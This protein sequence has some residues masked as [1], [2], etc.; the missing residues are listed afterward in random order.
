M[1]R[2]CSFVDVVTSATCPRL[3]PGQ[4]RKTQRVSGEERPAAARSG[5]L[6][7]HHTSGG[8][9]GR[10]ATTPRRI[11]VQYRCNPRRDGGTQS[12]NFMWWHRRHASAGE[13]DRTGQ[14]D[15]PPHGT[16]GTATPVQRIRPCPQHPYNALCGG[17]VL[18]D[19]ELRRNDAAFLDALG[20]RSIP[21]PTTAGDFCRRFG[22]E[23][24]QRLMD[25]INDV[26]V[27][28]WQ[29]QSPAFFKGT[30][31]ID[32]DGRAH[33]CR[34]KAPSCSTP[35]HAIRRAPSH[36][37]TRSCEPRN[38]QAED[39]TDTALADLPAMTDLG[40]PRI[41]A[42]NASARSWPT[43][44]RRGSASRR[45]WRWGMSD[46]IFLLPLRGS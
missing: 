8:G 12:R 29:R 31:R 14:G 5:S 27:G 11:C 18:D 39:C 23:D 13:Q 42:M 26:R 38:F 36:T 35:I 34:E 20:A 6:E 40:W 3:L 16:H 28:V 21:D 43:D 44:G 33:A 15:Q 30:A 41:R 10:P 17:L 4:P 7:D 1:H 22:P 9:E 37:S 46:A 2:A 24:I 45:A 32:A 25:I 19:I